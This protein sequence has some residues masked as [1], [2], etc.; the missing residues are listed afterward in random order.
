MLQPQLQRHSAN[1]YKREGI[2]RNNSFSA[3]C[4]SRRDPSS[5]IKLILFK[6]LLRDLISI[7]DSF[8]SF[9]TLSQSSLDWI[10]HVWWWYSISKQLYFHLASHNNTSAWHF[11][12]LQ[13]QHK[14]QMWVVESS[15]LLFSPPQM[16]MS[17]TGFLC[18]PSPF[19]LFKH[20]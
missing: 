14:P 10:Q 3:I 6:H 2:S 18:P 16:V 13:G 20:L 15:S 9:S 19:S 7:C 5:S 8:P 1:C 4:C 17:G 11:I 12:I